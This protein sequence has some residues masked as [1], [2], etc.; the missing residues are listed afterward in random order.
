MDRTAESA[1]HASRRPSRPEVVGCTARWLR[2]LVLLLALMAPLRAQPVSV[3]FACTATDALAC[4]DELN[5]C[6]RSPYAVG[7]STFLC[8]H[9]YRSAYLCHRDCGGVT[10]AWQQQCSSM[11]P[12]TL[13]LAFNPCDPSTDAQPTRT[14]TPTPVTTRVPVM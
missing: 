6:A 8:F 10:A 11:C 5:I 1:P 2:L 13:G 14:V 9:C 7:N 12:R 3:A 4:A